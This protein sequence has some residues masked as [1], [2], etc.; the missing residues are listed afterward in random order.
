MLDW[1]PTTQSFDS[2][3]Y[4]RSRRSLTYITYQNNLL[5]WLNF[6]LRDL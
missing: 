2:D 4:A 5:H 1:L 6:G 3:G